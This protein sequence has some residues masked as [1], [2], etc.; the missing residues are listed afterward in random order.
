MGLTAAQDGFARVDSVV[1]W[2]RTNGLY[3]ILD[4]HD[5]PGGQTG[6]NIDNCKWRNCEAQQGYIS[7]MLMEKSE[8]YNIKK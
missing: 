1:A 4:M 7:S 2:C 5:V 6:D 8:N 3:L